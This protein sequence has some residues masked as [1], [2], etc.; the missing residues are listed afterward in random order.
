MIYSVYWWIS[1][2]ISTLVV[3]YL[4]HIFN[5]EGPLGVFKA[6]A[7]FLLLLPG[8]NDVVK[9]FTQKEIKSFL[10]EQI[11]KKNTTEAKVIP[12]PEKGL[13]EYELNKELVELKAGN[14]DLSKNGRLFAYVYES[15]DTKFELQEK[16]FL[17][18]T[19]LTGSTEENG[20]DDKHTKITKAYM[21]TFLHDNALNPI[22]FPALRKFENE[23]VAM[24]AWMLNGDSSVVGSITSGGTESIL[25]AMKTHRDRARDLRPK[26]LQPNVVAPQTI[27]PAFAKAAHFLGMEMKY[28][29]V[30]KNTF[31]AD[32]SAMEAAVD[33]NTILLL[34]SAPSYPQAILDPIEELSELALKHHLPLH[35][36][37]CFGGFMLPWV[38]K[39]GYKIPL[40]DFRLPGVTSISADLHKYGYATKGASVIA[41]RNSSIRKYQF[42]AHVGWPGGLFISPTMAG[43]R[44]GGHLAASWAVVNSMGQDGYLNLA[45]KIMD[46][47][48]KNESW[49]KQH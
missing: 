23:V 5:K 43:T 35:V 2:V 40:W 12:I 13:N 37:A 26:I 45:R 21:R 9:T 24:T 38:E 47:T 31:Q 25:M 15:E 18:F 46:T 28:I 22:L 8:V 48:E 4:V 10:D 19:Q 34:G 11:E 16:A 41:Y 32:V 3:V 7:S 42:F 17:Q 29:P 27:H 6:V 36:D 20:D 39:L 49:S 30:L 1:T 14:K 44:P 33:E